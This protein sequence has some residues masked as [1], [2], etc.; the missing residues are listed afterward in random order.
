MKKWEVQKINDLYRQIDDLIEEN[1][2]LKADN[3]RLR[4]DL[5]MI[6]DTPDHSWALDQI[7]SD[8]KEIKSL[9]SKPEA[10]RTTTRKKPAAKKR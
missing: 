6:K 4:D 8:L 1:R 10:K 7:A 9:L 2:D 3:R 5:K